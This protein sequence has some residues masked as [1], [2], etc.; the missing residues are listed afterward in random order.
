MSKFAVLC[1]AIGAFFYA[2]SAGA[3]FLGIGCGNDDPS[4]TTNIT[5]KAYGGHATATSSVTGVSS[6]VVNSG[7]SKIVNS[8]NSHNV[9]KNTNKQNQA[10][11]QAQRQE[12][13]QAQL[14]GQ[15]QN[16]NNEGINVSVAG[17]VHEAPDMSKIPG[18][19]AGVIVDACSSGISGSMP[20]A[21]VTV[22]Q[23]NPV[24]LYLA[25]SNAA[26]TQGNKEKAE[27]YMAKAES[28]LHRQNFVTRW[29][30]WI[31]LI[32]QIL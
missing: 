10:Q 17:D 2:S 12:Q 7:N 1:V 28:H 15:K 23:G 21:G 29:L 5:N 8:G 13:N 25:M 30:S 6:K 26:Y 4:N 27:E 3:C 18:T 32:G 14:Q 31:P 11:L 24:C 9:N 19:P 22:G 20:G 16:A